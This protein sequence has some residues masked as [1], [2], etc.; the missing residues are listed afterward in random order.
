MSKTLEVECYEDHCDEFTAATC[1][2]RGDSAPA[3]KTV[4]AVFASH[5]PE[6]ERACDWRRCQEEPWRSL[7]EV[8]S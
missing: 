8:L 7:A 6:A 1:P 5:G 3:V 4:Q 2:L